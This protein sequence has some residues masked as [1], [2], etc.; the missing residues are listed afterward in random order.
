MNNAF[1]LA[2]CVEDRA[3]NDLMPFL[4]QKSFNGRFVLTSKGRLSKFLQKEIG[5]V[6]LNTS[7]KNVASVEIKS[8]QENKYGNLFLET[9]SN[10]QRFTVGWMYTLNADFL[11]YYF[12]ENRQLFICNFQALKKWAFIDSNIYKYTE[13]PQSKYTQ[14]NDTWGRCVPINIL[15]NEVCFKEYILEDETIPF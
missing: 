8:E 9:W 10:R 1:D 6:V 13:K 14:L 5:D 2:C 7:L 12:I 15:K 4:E 3:L 11:F